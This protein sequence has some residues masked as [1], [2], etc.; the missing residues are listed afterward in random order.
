ME[1][2]DIAICGYGPVGSTFAGLM[3][4][5]GHKVLVIERNVGPSPTAR[6]IN[7]DGEQLRTF[8][9][10]GIAEKVVENSTEVHCVHFG[11]AN[12]N[13]I[14][15][16]EQPVGVSAMGWPNQVLFYQPELEGFIRAS[17]ESE[18]NIIIKE[19]TEL[20]SFDNTAE[21]VTLNCKNSDGDISFFSK[22]LIGCD[23]ASSFVRR[24]LNV[25]LED[26]EY[27]QEWLVC[28]AHLTKKINIP[29]KEAMQVCDPKR[30]GTYVP[31]RRGHLRFEFKKM[32]GEDT[33]ELEKEENVWKLLKPWI[34]ENNAKLERAQVYSFHACI[35]ETWRKGNIL[36]A[37]DAAHQMPP[38][39][40]AGMGTGI[41]DVT[42]ISWK[43]NLLLKNKAK[44]GILDTYQKERH[45]HAKW[46][47]AQTVTI[48]QVIEGFCAAA[49]GKDYK[50]KGPSY[51]VNFPHIPSGIYSDP[52]DMITGVPIPQPILIKNDKK[53][54]LDRVID[55]TFAVLTKESNLDLTEK[56]KSIIDLLSIKLVTI[57]P[58][59]DSEERLKTVFE[60]YKA[61]LVRP[62]KY[63]YGGVEDISS[64]S[65]MIESLEK[66]FSL[67]L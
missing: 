3:G 1:K 10:L 45:S 51:D 53:E 40:G 56:A 48:G 29:E 52:A 28:D 64:L 67:N 4:K 62:D 35:A 33:E 32:P 44:E 54:M 50:P 21:G 59:E 22:Y 11:D 12:L 16:I 57:E 17:V 31:G 36:I 49:E 9:R 43:L 63:T 66:E 60:K 6:A 37:G 2:F 25:D 30:P 39:M 26:F 65:E 27:N 24:E 13:P 58:T 20:L 8:D 19:G 47:I 5:L 61:V 23:G 55:E 41:R 18:N 14:Q 34:N 42:N 7:T 38:F 15:T 46:T